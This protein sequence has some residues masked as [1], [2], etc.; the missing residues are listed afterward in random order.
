M[1]ATPNARRA[2]SKLTLNLGL[3]P[4]PFTH[5]ALGELGW[6]LALGVPTNTTRPVGRGEGGG[7][8]HEMRISRDALIMSLLTKQISKTFM[9]NVGFSKTMDGTSHCPK[10]ALETLCGSLSWHISKTT[11]GKYV[12]P[13]MRLAIS[14]S[15]QV[16]GGTADFGKL[17]LAT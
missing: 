7:T 8:L 16:W 6:P 3:G 17:S 9:A 1:C 10:R 14:R 4:P 15:T 13:K 11:F 2:P 12:F 5:L